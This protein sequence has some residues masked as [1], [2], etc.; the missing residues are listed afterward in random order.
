M[1]VVSLCFSGNPRAILNYREEW[2]AYFDMLRTEHELRIFFHCW[3]ET[4]LV[5]RSGGR[6]IEGTYQSGR[7]DSFDNLIA[8]LR[9]EAFRIESPVRSYDEIL[10]VMGDIYVSV[11]QAHP[12]A[13]LSQS[14]SIF[15]ADEVR[16]EHEKAH[17]P[18]DVV[19]RLRFDLK[20]TTLL[21]NEIR[22]IVRYPQ[23]EVLFAPSPT[24]HMHPG[25]GGG[26][27]G[28]HAFF[29][30]ERLQSDYG[31]RAAYFL[32]SHPAHDND[33]CD[34]YAT[35]NP[36]VMRRYSG[37]FARIAETYQEVK[38]RLG[39]HI[40]DYVVEP[41][42]DRP[43]ILKITGTRSGDFSL[44]ASP[45]FVPEKIIREGLRDVVIVHGESC[46]MAERR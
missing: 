24:W 29:D 10:D 31:A 23:H 17:G 35:G 8:F 38:R 36:E 6:F 40:S 14:H 32:R 11:V 9:P 18:S 34:L 43:G 2:Q 44:E 33:I 15:Q 42:G 5:R 27:R 21:M 12:R 20:P 39:E 41:D 46:F 4:G 25:G 22:Y 3:S 7:Y 13:I 26:C 19:I 1:A 45:I 37:A 16:R 30:R 28:C